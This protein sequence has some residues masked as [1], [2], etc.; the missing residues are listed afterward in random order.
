MKTDRTVAHWRI[1][2]LIDVL[3]IVSPPESGTMHCHPT[4]NIGAVLEGHATVE[5][6]GTSHDQPTG[7][8]I[9]FNVFDAHASAW[10]GE[11]NHYFVMNIGEEAWR[12]LSAP[13]GGGRARLMMRGPIA[14]DRI[15][16]HMMLGLRGELLT[17]P[18]GV[19]FDDVAAIVDAVARRGF[20]SEADTTPAETLEAFREHLNEA[21]EHG[22]GPIRIEDLAEHLDLSR[23]QLSRLLRNAIGMQPRRL[24]LQLMVATAQSEIA[25]GGALSSAAMRA[26]FS[27][28]SHMN[29]E[30]RRTLGITPK[31]YQRVVRLEAP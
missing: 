8:I 4:Y 15:L 11:R 16:F 1:G 6:D 10:H 19:G 21:V 25:A 17:R 18:E 30:F 9:L 12:R 14:Q 31:E 20:L 7:S 3:D 28:Q 22:E 27:D 13:L 26:G 23:F 2:D 29:R 24:R 5:S